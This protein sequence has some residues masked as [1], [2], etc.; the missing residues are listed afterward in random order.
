MDAEAKL[1]LKKNLRK[2]VTMYGKVIAAMQRLIFAI[3]ATKLLSIP[4]I[5]LIDSVL[6]YGQPIVILSLLVL[7][8]G[9]T[10]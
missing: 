3:I 7:I 5:Y 4:G 6:L 9:N 1:N 10:R 2:K 8:S